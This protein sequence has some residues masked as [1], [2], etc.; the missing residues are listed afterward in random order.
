MIPLADRIAGEF[1]GLDGVEAVALAGSRAAGRADSESDFDLYVYADREPPVEFRRAL[2]G[3]SAEVDNRFW[4]PG[5]EAALDGARVDIMYRQ[6]GWITDQLDRVLERHEASLGY[7]TCFWYNVLHSEILFDRRGW[8]SGLQQRARAPYPEALRRAI[9][10]KNWPVLRRNQSSYR[11]QIELA[12]ARG[13]LFS[14]QHRT[15]ALLASFFDIWFALEREPHPGEKRLIAWLPEAWARRVM[16]VLEG[17]N[18]LP[19]V[20]QLL[21]AAAAR[22]EEEGLLA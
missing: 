15:T 13:D 22:L 2:L 9:I 10:A 3:A 1:A 5:D 17:E 12:L 20:D 19:R 16:A 18:L 11:R 6:P 14:V 4:E 21:D 8:F 7:S